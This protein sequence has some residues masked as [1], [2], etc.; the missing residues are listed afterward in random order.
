MWNNKLDIYEKEWLEVVF[1]SRNQTYGAYDLRRQSAAATNKALLTVM[2]A[3]A[4]LVGGKYAYDRMPGMASA[5]VIEDNIPVTLDQ[6]VI[7]ETPKE[8]EVILPAEQPVQK[9]AQDPPA[10]ELIRFV[11]PVVTD[12]NR[13]VEDVASQDDLKDKMTARLTLKP[14]KGGSFVAKG[15]FGPTKEL[16]NIT[17]KASGDPNGSVLN[18][19]EPFVSVE[20]MPE[21]VGGMSAFV[22]WVGKNYAYP[23]RALEQG[24][25]GSVIATFVVETDGSLTDIAILRD[26]GFGTGDEAIRVLKKAAKWKPGV[27]NGL[28]VRVKYTLPIKLNTF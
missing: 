16:G 2:F 12:R 7:P 6:L 9:I 17:G 21:P 3:V 1:S 27:Q 8:E 26:I 18:N 24:I 20:V 13:A 4:L 23:D 25:K 11:E 15:E 28:P 22:N 5:P 19:G 10:Q 14:V